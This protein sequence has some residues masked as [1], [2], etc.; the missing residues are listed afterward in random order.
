[1]NGLWTN[2][3]TT[4][5]IRFLEFYFKIYDLVYVVIIDFENI[6]CLLKNHPTFRR[7]FLNFYTVS[8]DD[9]CLSL[10]IINFYILTN[11]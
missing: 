7:Q 5:Q 6:N 11:A 9:L 3:S 4:E 1:M 8:Y 10:V 2:G